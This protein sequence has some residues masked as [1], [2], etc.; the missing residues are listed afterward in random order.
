[1]QHESSNFYTKANLH[2]ASELTSTKLKC[3]T[4]K[5][6]MCI[7]Y[8]NVIIIHLFL[9]T[10]KYLLIANSHSIFSA[11]LSWSYSCLRKMVKLAI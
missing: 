11:S 10:C 8:T 2:I 1:M 7:N 6:R 4:C 5:H 9:L 3:Q